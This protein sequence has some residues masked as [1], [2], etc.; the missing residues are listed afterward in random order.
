MHPPASS[1]N[2]NQPVNTTA[3]VKPSTCNIAAPYLTHESEIAPGALDAPTTNI[4][5]TH[6]R[7]APSP[8]KHFL[9]NHY[10]LSTQ[11][12]NFVLLTWQLNRSSKPNNGL[13]TGH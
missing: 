5:N 4:P 6:K 1:A 8:L 13:H 9:K 7:L 10:S 3:E 2:P 11:E 12:I